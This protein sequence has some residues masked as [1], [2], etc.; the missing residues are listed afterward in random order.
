MLP[1]FPKPFSFELRGFVFAAV[2][3]LGR[4]IAVL[5]FCHTSLPVGMVFSLCCCPSASSFCWVVIT[6]RPQHVVILRYREERYARFFIKT[7]PLFLDCSVRNMCITCESQDV[8]VLTIKLGVA[9]TMPS[10]NWQWWLVIINFD[11]VEL[12]FFLVK[13]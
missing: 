5:L 9:F 3:A 8:I 13:C 11:H 10:Y 2:A 7:S 12:F 4:T 6:G 1:R